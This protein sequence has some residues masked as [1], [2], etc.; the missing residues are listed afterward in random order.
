[1][2]TVILTNIINRK[3]ILF[4]LNILFIKESQFVFLSNVKNYKKLKEYD[5]VKL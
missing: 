5:I 1:M 3:E 4:K 2:R